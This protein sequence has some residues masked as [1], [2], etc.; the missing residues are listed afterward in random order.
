MTPYDERI[1]GALYVSECAEIR[2]SNTISEPQEDHDGVLSSASIYTAITSTSSLLK[3]PSLE[4]LGLTSCIHS[5]SSKSTDAV[6]FV[7]VGDSCILSFEVVFSS[8]RGGRAD[9]TRILLF[10]AASIEFEYA[11]PKIESRA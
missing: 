7:H 2:C 6:T 8:R 9:I 4:I 1:E 3:I 11:F 5:G 10:N